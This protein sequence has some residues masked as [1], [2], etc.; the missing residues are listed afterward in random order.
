MMI[1]IRATGLGTHAFADRLLDEHDVSVLAGEAFGASAAGFV[2]LSLTVDAER[3]REACRRIERCA[4]ECQG[5]SRLAA[6]PL[7][8]MT[9]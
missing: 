4:Q 2:R 9:S 5:E 1:D 3:L 7:N 6:R 8:G